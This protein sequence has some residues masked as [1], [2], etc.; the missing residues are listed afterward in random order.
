MEI[1]VVAIFSFFF[2]KI[3]V[4]GH[5]GNKDTGEKSIWDQFHGWIFISEIVLCVGMLLKDTLRHV[6]TFYLNEN[7]FE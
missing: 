2:K 1:E 5:V 4:S 3:S 6:K 7:P